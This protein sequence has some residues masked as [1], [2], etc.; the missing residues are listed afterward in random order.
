MTES[1]GYCWS[2]SGIVRPRASGRVGP[3]YVTK[4]PRLVHLNGPPGIGKSTLA[5]RYVDG[6]PLAF[7]LDIGGFRSLIGR[8]EEQEQEAGRLARRLALAMAREH[9]SSVHDVVVPQLV[10]KPEFVT[11]THDLAAEVGAQFYEVVLLADRDQAAARFE[12]SSTDAA[13]AAHHATAS[14]MLAASGGY[15]EM[16][17]RVAAVIPQLPHAV[18]ITTVTGEARS[19]TCSM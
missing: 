1:L 11:A 14:R 15:A 2:T 16:Y 19:G 17:D 9:L 4:V 13:W 8:W 6:H 10:A 5:R 12:A 18:V 3:P 7:C